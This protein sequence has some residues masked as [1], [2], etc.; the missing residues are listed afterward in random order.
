MNV[1]PAR[2][3]LLFTE[4]L[5]HANH[6]ERHRFLSTACGHD[7]G[8]WN[9]V[10]DLLRNHFGKDGSHGSSGGGAAAPTMDGEKPG[11]V[12]GDCHLLQIVG[13]GTSTVVWM[14]ER[15][16]PQTT[17]VALKIVNTGANDFLMR[18]AAAMPA[19]MLLEH[20]GIARVHDT[21]MT[22]AGRPFIISDVVS[23]VPILKFCDDQ[24]LALS[25]R[26][27]LFLQVC[28]AVHHAH[29]KGVAHGNL[30][31]GNVLVQ[32]SGEGQPVFTI[33]DFGFA[34]A[35]GPVVMTQDGHLRTPAAYLAPELVGTGKATVQGDILSLGTLLFELIT[36]R[37][38]FA[39]PPQIHSLDELRRVAREA[40]PM[41]PSECLHA[42]PKAQLT[43]IALGRKTE[44]TRLLELM[45]IHFD[46]VLMRA[47]Q[48]QP[49]G[50]PE[51]LLMLAESLVPYLKAAEE[52]EAPAP[53]TGESNVGHFFFQNRSLFATAA[54]LV[55]LLTAAAA[56]LGWLWVRH[57]KTPVQAISKKKPEGESP[58]TEFLTAMFAGLT[59]ERI[60]GH[61]TTL[62]K[63]MLDEATGRLDTL[64]EYPEAGAQM[65]ETIGLTYMAMSETGSAQKQLQ[66]ALE[67]RQNALGGD[68]PD[69]LRS[70]RQMAE[71]F[72]KEGHH[73]EAE[74]LLR[75]T[76]GAQQRVLGPNH[77]D[78]FIT[79]TVLAAVCEAQDRPMD[80]EELFVNLWKLQ[81]QV[82]GPDHMETL[83]TM[84]NLAGLMGR[85]GRHDEVIEMEKERLDLTRQ[86]L[87]TRH[88]RT[89][90]A[91]TITAAAY[92][93][94]G[95]PSEAEKMYVGAMKIMKEALGPTHPDTLE[96][97]DKAALAQ[98]EQG[99]PR[100]ALKLH[101]EALDARRSTLGAQ[102]P[103]TLMS[104]RHVAED[105]EADGQ[106]TAAEGLQLDVLDVLRNAC[107]P[108]HAD[109]LAQTETVAETYESHG[110]HAEALTLHQQVLQARKHALGNNHPQTVH[111]MSLV[112]RSLAASGR[113]AEAEAMQA[114]LLTS[115]KASLGV[116]D[117]DT[118]A[119]MH[120][121]ARMQ[122]QHGRQTQAEKTWNE[123]LQIQTK[124][125]GVDH[126]DTLAT[127]QCLA[128]ACLAQNRVPEAE[129]IHL[130][131]LQLE[132]D[133]KQPDPARV[134]E[135]AATLGR[136]WLQLNRP[137]EAEP[138]LREC[139][140][141]HQKHQPDDWRRF[142]AESVLG[143][144][145][146]C[147]K[148][149]AEAGPLLR[150]G[151]EGLSTRLAT[152]PK[153]EHFH[154]RDAIERMGRFV[155]LSDGPAAAIEWRHKLAA[156]DQSVQL[157]RN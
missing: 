60:K 37:L 53:T 97:M 103:D 119:Q 143:D 110:R 36:G 12:L 149:M 70:M 6:I 130:Q 126:P 40:P 132:R 91:M 114:E 10:W 90:A 98:R 25:A 108:E 123:I 136:F 157:A 75:K 105:L 22:N 94:G 55:L 34:S 16:T 129:K 145:L 38:P 112:A 21:G 156:F 39:T 125:L 49:H 71:V 120:A 52:E 65:Q 79:I 96:T 153:T 151:H 26:V 147:L 59:P 137:A 1:D 67:K 32:W 41:K 104:M 124:A 154:V 107:G 95:E 78:T 3:E 68:H 29:E 83:A 118:L 146:L 45:E 99:R 28:E 51:S 141:L 66:G 2:I 121:L 58:T 20:P 18:H 76:L 131:V 24:K 117:P 44:P 152:I 13:E 155:E 35:M 15:H 81:K 17:C 74:A 93:A 46:G 134:A 47:L 85:Q 109:T 27:R 62:L 23:G 140:N 64:K 56:V 61:D 33:T 42:L 72:H 57:E 133:R 80:S 102:H 150:S 4:A 63:G 135:S 101:Q 144:A 127:L 82:L 30:K 7:A 73:P 116:G 8:L 142:S 43:G 128:Q 11:D 86:K 69:T 139:L 115:M 77:P 88:P 111:S 122:Q 87:G 148:R 100:D 14:A 113:K 89:L 19:L 48:K 31:P 138:L 84:G 50:R 54:A 106:K 92:E 9:A 5:T